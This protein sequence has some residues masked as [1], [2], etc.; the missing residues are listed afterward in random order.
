MSEEIIG[1]WPR[2]P[3]DLP[4]PRSHLV[5]A[6]NA[7]EMWNFLAATMFDTLTE[8]IPRILA[9]ITPGPLGIEPPTYVMTYVEEW[10]LADER[11]YWFDGKMLAN[12]Q[13]RQF[14]ATSVDEFLSLY[15]NK[16]MVLY[17]QR[18]GT[19]PFQAIRPRPQDHV[20]TWFM[21]QRKRRQRGTVVTREGM[22][23]ISLR[24][25]HA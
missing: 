5:T 13:R 6:M 20:E 9:W 17:S 14:I 21:S 19:D 23:P 22:S 11:F 8:A 16:A 2:R 12:L 25:P 24:V 10:D 4:N 3:R 18:G 7:I 1:N 15:F